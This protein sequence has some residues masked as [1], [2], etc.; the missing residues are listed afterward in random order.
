MCERDGTQDGTKAEGRRL[1][2]SYHHKDQIWEFDISSLGNSE[3][4]TDWK[5]GSY[6][7][8]PQRHFVS[9]FERL[10]FLVITHCLSLNYRRT[11]EPVHACCSG[12]DTCCGNQGYSQ[13][14]P[15]FGVACRGGW[16]WGGQHAWRGWSLEF[17]TWDSPLTSIMSG[18]IFHLASKMKK[19]GM[20]HWFLNAQLP[21]CHVIQVL[22]II[23][24][25]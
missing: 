12:Q 7:I 20:E 18:S 23:Y 14:L 21:N 6:L 22:N 8:N 2:E 3:T 5:V 9:Q 17:L 19:A 15:V 16:I 24:F 11:V 4:S 13:P 10:E 1:K 25:I